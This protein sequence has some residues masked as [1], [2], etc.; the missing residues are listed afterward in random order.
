MEAGLSEKLT[1]INKVIR[2]WVDTRDEGLIPGLRRSPGGGNGNPLQYSCLGN[3]MDRGTWQAIVHGV[4][5]SW[6]RLSYC[7]CTHKIQTH[8]LTPEEG[9]A[10]RDWG[11]SL[12]ANDLINCADVRSFHK[13]S[14]GQ[15]LTGWG[16]QG[17]LGR[18]SHWQRSSVPLLM[19]LALCISSIGCSWV[20]SLYNKPISSK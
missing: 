17:D 6:T 8:S 4:T 14:K 5:K 9:K 1:E 13:I 19:Y 3:P 7:A 16:T 10:S 15:G 2:V 11:Q 12:K 18:V 20:I